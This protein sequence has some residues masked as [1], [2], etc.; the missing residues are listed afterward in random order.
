MARTLKKIVIP[1]AKPGIIVAA[2][3]TFINCLADFGTPIFIGGGFD[4]LATEAYLNVIAYY[5]LPGS[6]YE[7]FN[8]VAGFWYF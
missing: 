6:S 2:L 7:H 5:N 3:L 8:Y 1:L 4:V